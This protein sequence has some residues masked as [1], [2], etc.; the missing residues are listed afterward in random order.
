VFDAEEKGQQPMP[1]L[2][3]MVSAPSVL[4]FPLKPNRDLTVNLLA[5]QKAKANVSTRTI[6]CIFNELQTPIF[7]SPLYSYPY[8]LVGVFFFSAKFSQNKPRLFL[9]TTPCYHR[10]KSPPGPLVLENGELS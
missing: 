6:P 8:K 7:A 5:L 9:S 10:A 2:F 1:P 4:K 3:V